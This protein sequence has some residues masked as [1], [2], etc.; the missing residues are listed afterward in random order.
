MIKSIILIIFLNFLPISAKNIEPIDIVKKTVSEVLETIQNDKE[1]KAGNKSK[2]IEIV[3]EK[4]TPYVDFERMT[5]LAV[6]RPWK[7]ATDTQ[8]SKL[9]DSFNK[10]LINSYAAAF[11]NYLG[12]VIEVGSQKIDGERGTVMSKVKLPGGAPPLSIEYD[13]LYKKSWKLFDVKID[14]SSMIINYRSMFSQT[15]ATSGID[16]LLEVLEKKINE[17]K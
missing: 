15:I 1:I 5:R 9:I 14:G 12:I 13:F 11:T 8:K 7:E 16:G 3:K 10:L 17:T 2:I 6:G 4:V